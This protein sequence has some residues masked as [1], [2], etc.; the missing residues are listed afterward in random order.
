M[1]EGVQDNLHATTLDRVVAF[2]AVLS[3]LCVFLLPSQ[4]GASFPTYLLAL[5]VLGGGRD[6]WRDFFEARILS[7]LLISLLVYF[8]SS[9][10]WSDGYS[11]RGAFSVYTRCLLIV[12]F[13]AAIATSLRR[14]P[15]L[16]QWL[17]RSLAVGA[18]IAAAAAL[19]AFY[20]NPTWDGRLAGLGQLRNSVVA[21]LAFGIGLVLA[22]GVLLS[23]GSVWRATGAVCAVLL[24]IAVFAT[25]SRNA[26]LSGAIGAWVLLLTSCARQSPRLLFWFAVPLVGLAAVV[27]LLAANPAWTD[28]LFP[29]GD[30]FRLEIWQAEWR[31]LVAQGPWF[32]LGI[33]VRD[34]VVLQGRGF[35]HPHSLY[36]A[37]ALQGGLVGLLLLLAVLLYAGSILYRARR[38]QAARLGAALLATG[39]SAY[40]FDGWELI[41]KVSLSW[42]LI[43]VPVAIAMGVGATSKMGNKHAMAGA[44]LTEQSFGA[45][46]DR[47]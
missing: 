18:G 41:D 11:L 12:A 34:D 7:V 1:S 23:S 25:G 17:S 21:G 9:V 44:D 10:W 29:R 22:L 15:D 45:A 40:L 33:L 3:L 19:I 39:V 16:T 32:G 6:R 2:L 14:F 37:S 47:R 5:V 26:Y 46:G 38:L 13:I 24:G 35:S 42:L 28:A 31:R 30:S 8:S 20:L 4:S 43:W 27:A 36:L